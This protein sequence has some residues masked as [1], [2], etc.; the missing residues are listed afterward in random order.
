MNMKKVI[1]VAAAYKL[2]RLMAT[3]TILLLITAT[4]CQYL[5][6]N[7]GTR[8]ATAYFYTNN[9]AGKPY[10]LFIENAYAGELPFLP[11]SLTT[12]GN[13]VVKKTGLQ[14]VV[15]PGSYPLLVKDEEGG[16]V[17]E[18]KLTIRITSGSQSISSSWNN[19]KCKVEVVIN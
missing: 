10:R 14:V 3:L 7:D 6:A 16:V 9:D 15:K 17:C 4:S 2:S 19:G 5:E 18:G 11:D 13:T 1:P 8:T 12:P